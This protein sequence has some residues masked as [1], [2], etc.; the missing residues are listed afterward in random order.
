MP[1]VPPSCCGFCGGALSPIEGKPGQRLCASGC[2]ETT[3]LSPVPVVAAI[4]EH[5][6]G[7]VLVR[8]H[9]WPDDWYGLV[10]GF[11]EPDESPQEAILRE[12]REELSVEGAVAALIGAYAFPPMNQVIIAFHVHVQGHVALDRGELADFKFVQRRDL[13][14]WDFGTGP[15]VRDFLA[16]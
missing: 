16:A 11:L 13:V 6:T 2:G 7:I 14:P 8:S 10:T 12:V 3:Y 15:A 9:G 4:V 1:Y 5:P